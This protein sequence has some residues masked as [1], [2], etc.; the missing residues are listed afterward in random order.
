MCVCRSSEATKLCEEAKKDQ[1]VRSAQSV[2]QNR[3][4][5]ASKRAERGER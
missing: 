2:L 1:A 5:I 4:H 3:L